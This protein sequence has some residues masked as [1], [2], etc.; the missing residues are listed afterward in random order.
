MLEGACG[1]RSLTSRVFCE[2]SVRGW[3]VETSADALRVRASTWFWTVS[4]AVSGFPILSVLTRGARHRGARSRRRSRTRATASTPRRLASPPPRGRRR[5][6]TSP[7]SSSHSS[8]SSTS[9]SV[10]TCKR[11]PFPLLRPRWMCSPVVSLQRGRALHLRADVREARR[12]RQRQQLRASPSPPSLFLPPAVLT[13][14]SA[15][16]LRPRRPPASSTSTT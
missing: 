11:P 8:S 16:R 4:R 12:E 9:P 6:A 10:V 3:S 5:R 14:T 1:R 2:C 7:S 13:L 15:F